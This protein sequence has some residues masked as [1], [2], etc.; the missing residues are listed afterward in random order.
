MKKFGNIRTWKRKSWYSKSISAKINGFNR[1]I[2]S[3]MKYA[4]S[5]GS[6]HTKAF[7]IFGVISCSV[8]FT[9]KLYFV[10]MI[11][12]Y[13]YPIFMPIDRD[14]LTYFAVTTYQLMA[15]TSILLNHMAI[16]GIFFSVFAFIVYQIKILGYRY[17]RLGH[18]NPP[19]KGSRVN[20]MKKIIEL[21]HLKLDINK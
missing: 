14:G 7:V 11:R 8:Y 15:A 16:D 5:L 13:I 19:K 6:F 10:I 18:D 2:Y 9:I 4:R 21:I 3:I 20:C 17:S 12:E 1:F